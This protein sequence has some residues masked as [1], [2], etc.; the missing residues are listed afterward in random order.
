[1]KNTKMI[2]DSVLSLIL[3]PAFFVCFPTIESLAQAK[4][5]EIISKVNTIGMYRQKAKFLHIMAKD[6]I[7]KFNG[8][9]PHTMEEL[10]SL[11]GG[12]RKTASVVLVISFGKKA[13]AVDTHVHRV[14]NRL[15]WV[16]TSTPEQTEKALLTLIPKRWH[17]VVNR[18]F[19]K[20]GRYICLP[21]NPRCFLC[22]VR[23]HCPFQGKNLVM[24]KQEMMK[25]MEKEIER[26]EQIV[27][28][29]RESIL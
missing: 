15:G 23:M 24:P 29:L 27:E 28:T 14:T 25:R 26:R 6:V 7:R 8:E 21:G 17:H 19:V 4:V 20:H 18:V 5:E 3:L 16:K 2:A 9:I 1:M 22:P 11:G 10:V 12:G 13:I